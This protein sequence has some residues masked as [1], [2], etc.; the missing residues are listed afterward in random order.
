MKNHQR[1]LLL[2]LLTSFSCDQLIVKREHRDDIKEEEWHKLNRSE[3]DEP[4]LFKTC[5]DEPEIDGMQ[6]FQ[7]TLTQHIHNYINKDVLLVSENITDTLW[8]SLLVNT[9]GTIIIENYELPE[10][11]SEQLPDLESLLTASVSSLPT[12]EPAHLRGVP[13]NVRYRL[14]VVLNTN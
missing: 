3:V 9:N 4:P 14:P 2:L 10:F 1:I 11:L 12:V 8:V 5:A 6:C 13:V 7:Q